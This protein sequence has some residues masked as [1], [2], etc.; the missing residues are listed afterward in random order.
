MIN[1]VATLQIIIQDTWTIVFADGIERLRVFGAARECYGKT[2]AQKTCH[3]Y[4]LDI[5]I[6]MLLDNYKNYYGI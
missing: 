4:I 2:A 5:H 6:I 1:F 3:D